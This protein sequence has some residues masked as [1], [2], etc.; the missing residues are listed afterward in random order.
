VIS[1]YRAWCF[2]KRRQ[3]VWVL[4]LKAPAIDAAFS[5]YNEF[6]NRT[7]LGSLRG[8][9]W[10]LWCRAPKY[11]TITL[12]SRKDIFTIF[13]SADA[14]SNRYTIAL[15][16]HDAIA[17]RKGHFGGASIRRLQS[18]IFR[19]DWDTDGDCRYFDASLQRGNYMGRRS[20]ATSYVHTPAW[21]YT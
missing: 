5:L 1:I 10:L 20:K 17:G 11:F 9:R 12:F 7:P 2:S 21:Y 14:H 8:A 18:T 13:R 3:F 16:R 19:F 15:K 6:I 4:I